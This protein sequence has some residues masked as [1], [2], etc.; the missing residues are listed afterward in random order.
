MTTQYLDQS[1]LGFQEYIDRQ[2]RSR[3]SDDDSTPLYAHPV[4]EWILRTINAAPVKSVLD[5]SLDSVISVFLGQYLAT[6]IFIDQKSF[7]DLF[8]VL[9]HCAETLGIPIPHAVAGDSPDLFNAFTAGTEEYSF[10]YI[11]S[12][13]CKYFS[14]EEACFV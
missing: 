4:D 6:S 5:K 13:L 9:S 14:R 3:L 2:A 11:T 7:P 1:F 10:I 8:E 12:G